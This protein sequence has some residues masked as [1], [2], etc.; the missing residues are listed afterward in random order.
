V[1]FILKQKISHFVFNVFKNTIIR[2]KFAKKEFNREAIIFLIVN[3]NI[4]IKIYVKNVIKIS[5]FQ[6][7]ALNAYK[8]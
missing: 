5:L 7:M 8:K 4:F 3:K 1:I 6:V 2:T